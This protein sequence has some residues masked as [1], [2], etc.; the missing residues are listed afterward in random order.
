MG[1]VPIVKP[2]CLKGSMIVQS[3]DQNDGNEDSE[4]DITNS[5]SHSLQ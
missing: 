5:E 4:S 3:P 1:I 2:I